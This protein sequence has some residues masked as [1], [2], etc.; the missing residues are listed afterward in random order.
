[1]SRKGDRGLVLS[2]IYAAC[3]LLPAGLMLVFIFGSLILVGGR[4]AVT[5]SEMWPQVFD[6]PLFGVPEWLLMVPAVVGAAVVIPLCVLTDAAHWSRLLAAVRF[7]LVAVGAAVFFTFVFTFAN[8]RP[9]DGW[10]LASITAHWW[11]LP[12]VLFSL[13]VLIVALIAKGPEYERL[14]KSGELYN[15]PS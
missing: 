8:E 11:A 9:A 7:T 5:Q 1:M 14:R 10:S 2:R 3:Q 12:F 13:V 4:V 15:T 6:W